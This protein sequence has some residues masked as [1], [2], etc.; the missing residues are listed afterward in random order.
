MDQMVSHDKLNEQNDLPIKTL[1]LLI[2]ISLSAFEMLLPRIPLL[3]WLKPGLANIIT[4]LWIIRFG[5]K[6]AILF[7]FLRSWI[8]GFYFGFS[9]TTFILSLGG[10]VLSTTVMGF[11][12]DLFGRNKLIGTIGMGMI[13]AIAHNLGQLSIIYLLM[14]RNTFIFYQLPF[15]CGASLLFGAIIGSCAPFFESIIQKTTITT[16]HTM[17]NH[18]SKTAIVSVDK[19]IFANIV[20]TFC[21]ILVFVTSFWI[22]TASLLFITI[23]IGL[24]LG[25]SMKK[26]FYP[27]RFWALFLFIAVVYL[28]FSYGTRIHGIPLLTRE[29]LHETATQFLRLWIWLE[30]SFLLHHFQFHTFFFRV[31]KWIFP[32]HI[33]TF[34]AGLLT[35]EY[36]PEMIRFSRSKESREG[37]NFIRQP[38]QSLRILLER[39]ILQIESIF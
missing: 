36:F 30:A 2:S 32:S 15:M 4:I 13:G 9:F 11:A 37:L 26:V 17:Q 10:G 20:F 7:A 14:A 5:A 12:W 18:L 33:T 16:T 31:L 28:F 21:I 23:A 25:F 27:L 29:G 35:L 19:V 38:L 24:I 3:P 8:T 39:I 6:D 34:S 22:L 1:W